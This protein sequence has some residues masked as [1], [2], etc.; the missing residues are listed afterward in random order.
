MK[1]VA[2]TGATGLVGGA[3]VEYLSSRGHDVV[4]IARRT[5]PQLQNAVQSKNAVQNNND[6]KVEIRIADVADQQALAQAFANVDCVVHAAGSVDPFGS[7]QAI[8]A[9]NVTG[10]KNALTAAKLAKVKHFIFISSLSVITG[11]GDL[12]DVDESAPLR[13]CGESYADSKVEAEKAVMSEAG[14]DQI[15]VTSLRPGFIY[16]R[17]ENSWMPRLI[18]SISTGKAMLIDGGTKQTN[19]IYVLN[20]AQAVELAILNERSYSQVYN[21]TD[22]ETVTKKQLFDAISDGLNLPRVTKKV[23]GAIAK[24]FCELVSTFAPMLPVENQRKLARF[25]RAAFRLAGINQGFSIQKAERELN[26]VTRIPF[27]QGMS[28]TLATFKSTATES[29]LMTGAL[30]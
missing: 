22:G 24:A 16:G 19:V 2:V 30:K 28:E 7:R 23:P 21:L 13:H 14:S 4:A 10:T 3:L 15:Q 1:T 11:Q 29:Q 25:S 18:N 27:T 17:G 6:G 8:F 9:T 20:L 5:S 12:Y 26:Y